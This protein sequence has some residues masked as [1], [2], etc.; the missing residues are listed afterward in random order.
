MKHGSSLQTVKKFDAYMYVLKCSDFVKVG[1]TQNI[2]YRIS[3]IKS[4]NPHPVG[5]AWSMKVSGKVYLAEQEAHRALREFHVRGEWFSCKVEDAILALKNAMVEHE[6]AEWS[7]P[8]PN[9]WEPPVFDW[10]FLE[11]AFPRPKFHPAR[12]RS[13]P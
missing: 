4:A 6:I 9:K 12:L 13:K 10:N 8:V 1:I 2:K 11:G 5:I 3:S 7:P